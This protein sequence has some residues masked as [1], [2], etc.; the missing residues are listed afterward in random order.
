MG[1]SHVVSIKQMIFNENLTLVFWDPPIVLLG[2]CDLQNTHDRYR[3]LFSLKIVKIVSG[4]IFTLYEIT[5][6]KK[7]I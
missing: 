3:R 7:L 1:S 5:I 6:P 4:Y 2:F